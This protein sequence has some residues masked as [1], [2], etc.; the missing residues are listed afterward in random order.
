VLVG[1]SVVLVR[2]VADC[3]LLDR[4]REVEAIDRQIRAMPGVSHTEMTYH[5]GL[6][7]GEI[8]NLVVS[9]APSVTQQ[10]AANVGRVF[11]DKTRHGFGGYQ[12]EIDLRY[13]ATAPQRYFYVPDYSEAWFKFDQATAGVNPSASDVRTPLRCGCTRCVHRS[14]NESS[15]VSRRGVQMQANVTS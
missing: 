1:L 12:L 10:Q 15:S 6:A 3:F 4:R 5:H 8:F 13:P 7:S 11:V 14:S 9:L 2:L